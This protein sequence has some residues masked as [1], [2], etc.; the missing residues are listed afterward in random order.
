ML[1]A[2][3]GRLAAKI[4]S[5][6]LASRSAL[7]STTV[8]DAQFMRLSS[9]PIRNSVTCALSSKSAQ[10]TSASLHTLSRRSLASSSR[11]HSGPSKKAWP[12]SSNQGARFMSVNLGPKFDTTANAPRSRLCTSLRWQLFRLSIPFLYCLGYILTFYSLF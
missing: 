10:T 2:G 12:S 4:A 9:L 11:V 3:G 1:Q 7:K 6:R 8:L 5:A